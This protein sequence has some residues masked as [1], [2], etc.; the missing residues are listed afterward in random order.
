MRNKS[1]EMGSGFG[2]LELGC[3]YRSKSNWQMK[4]L[5]LDPYLKHAEIP[6]SL[7]T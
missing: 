5:L 4:F 3:S 7:E 1:Y 2:S 6:F